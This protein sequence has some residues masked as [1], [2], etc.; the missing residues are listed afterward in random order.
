ML[1]L[2][3]K[4]GNVVDGT[5]APGRRANVAVAD[6]RIVGVGEVD[7]QA[8]RTIDAS[9]RVV[10]PGFVDVHTHYDVQVLWDP[11]MSPSPLHG[12]TTVIGGN[13]GFSIAPLGPGHADYVMKMMAR[14]EGM[15]LEALQQGPAWDWTS[16]AEWLDRLE[17]RVG[18]NAGFL[19]GHSTIRRVVMGDGAHDRANAAQI[20]AMTG[21][22]H[23]ALA[24]GALGFSSSL[25]EAH[26]DYEGRPVPSRQAQ[27]EEFLALATAVRPHEGTA[28]EMIPAMGEIPPERIE[29]MTRMSLAANRPLNW[30]LLGSLSPTEVYRQQLTSCDH[31]HRNGAVVVALALPDLLRMRAPL[32]ESLP[33]WP[34]VLGLPDEERR[35]AAADGSVRA[36]LRSSTP[37]L[38]ATVGSWDLIA[39]AEGPRAGRTVAS[40]ASD[41][42]IDAEDALIDSVVA[43]AVPVM[44]L[45]P[46]LTP[47]L[48]AT[49]EGW[50]ERSRVW[51]D[52][53]VVLGGSDAGAHA[54]L[55]CHA[56]YTTVVLGEMTRQRGLFQLEDA[57][58]RLTDVPA[59]LYGL[60]HRG[61]IAE[62]WFA[63]LVVFDPAEVGSRPPM[64]RYDQPAGSMRL[65]AEAIGVEHVMV[66]GGEVVRSGEFTGDLPGQLLRSGRDTDTVTVPGAT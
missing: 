31:A 66:N 4:D 9:G 36:R 24:A 37:Q 43:E 47:T 19:A 59:R 28:L 54:D 20:E 30:N 32:L 16:Y 17:G 57:I 44:V 64:A 63:D 12:V 49:P 27:P 34:E 58:R 48:G 61:R 33:D 56:N 46:S 15:P 22:L 29:L 50:A 39:L 7:D 13:C 53:R 8:V 60:R 51:R 41:L 10:C 52:E 18:I 55:M 2:L 11:A 14:V 38:L 45:F 40:I 1:D 21:L 23:E 5:G 6:G 65:Y 62:G 42:G 26:T 3:I 35:R 25:G